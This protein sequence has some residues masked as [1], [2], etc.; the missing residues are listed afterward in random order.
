MPLSPLSPT[1][2]AGQ[3]SI[4][5]PLEDLR[6]FRDTTRTELEGRAA[7]SF[8][9]AK[10]KGA[11]SQQ[12]RLYVATAEDADVFEAVKDDQESRKPM[13]AAMRRNTA[14]TALFDDVDQL[15]SFDFINGPNP[16][17]H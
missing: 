14:S 9:L 12:G 11:G 10:A 5:G 13:L 6:L 15:M 8:L 17:A 2:F 3:W 16:P 7:C 4:C 1:R